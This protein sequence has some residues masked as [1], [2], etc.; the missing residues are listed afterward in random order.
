MIRKSP[1]LIEV[2]KSIYEFDDSILNQP[3]LFKAM[4]LDYYTGTSCILEDFNS[5]VDLLQDHI[6]KKEITLSKI[7]GAIRIVNEDRR[8]IQIEL[9]REI[10]I[11]RNIDA[12]ER[13]DSYIRCVYHGE[14]MSSERKYSEHISSSI[15]DF[16]ANRKD[17]LVW[18]EEIVISWKCNNPFRLMFSNGHEEMDV[19]RLNS[20]D[21]SAMCDN[22]NLTL[23]DSRGLVVEQRTINITYLEQAFCNECGTPAYNV[24]DKYCTKCG[25]K[26]SYGVKM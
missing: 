19:T 12:I 6:V 16:S 21:I 13:L 14:D 11:D 4:L 15:L 10:F 9:F 18:G 26:L 5:V 20:I 3:R 23:Y 25:V 24:G 8:K 2:I 22:Y 1:S 17:S 7:T